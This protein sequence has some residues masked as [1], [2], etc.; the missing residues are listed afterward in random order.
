MT[1][2]ISF[3]QCQGNESS[4]SAFFLSNS[5][6]IWWSYSTGTGCSYIKWQSILFCF[7]VSIWE[8]KFY[9]KQNSDENNHNQI[10]VCFDLCI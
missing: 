6:D 7:L 2:I 8:F 3:V 9:L 10:D 5:N 1:I 4:N